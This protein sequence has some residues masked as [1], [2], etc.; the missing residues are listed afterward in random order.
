MQWKLGARTRPR[1]QR[2][3]GRSGRMVAS[4]LQFHWGG[5]RDFTLTWQACAY[6]WTRAERASFHWVFTKTP[7]SLRRCV[8]TSL[9]SPYACWG[10]SR[11]R[12]GWINTWSPWQTWPCW[13]CIRG[14]CY[15]NLWWCALWK[16]GLMVCLYGPQWS[17]CIICRLWLSV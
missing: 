17:A 12:R 14:G 11:G 6:I 3:C 10:S 4:R 9:T 2:K 1:Q 13:G 16:E 5:M 8:E 15:K 7:C